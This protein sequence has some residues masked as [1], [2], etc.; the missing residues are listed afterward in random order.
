MKFHFGRVSKALEA[1][2]GIVV[3]LLLLVSVGFC[4]VVNAHPH[5]LPEYEEMLRE[6]NPVP[7]IHQSAVAEVEELPES[8]QIRM[9]N[10]YPGVERVLIV[11]VSTC[12]PAGTTYFW[13]V[14]PILEDGRI[15]TTGAAY[16]H[17][18]VPGACV[19]ER[20]V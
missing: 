18:F 20:V 10:I 14:T 12:N 1:L 9:R 13:Y 8:V 19:A 16:P 3:I 4:A 15:G 2:F 11:L 7:V 5:T 6:Q 17:D